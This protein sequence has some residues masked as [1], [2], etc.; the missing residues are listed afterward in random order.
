APPERPSFVSCY[1]LLRVGRKGVCYRMNGEEMCTHGRTPTHTH[2]P[3]SLT[4]LRCPVPLRSA[5]APPRS[6]LRAP[7]LPAFAGPL[8]C[9]YWLLRHRR[10]HYN[11]FYLSIHHSLS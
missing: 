1:L 3:T 8:P 11:I 9:C 10:R 4:S 7:A 2:I 6:S 5:S